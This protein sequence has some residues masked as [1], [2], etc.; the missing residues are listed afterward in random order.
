MGKFPH[1]QYAKINSDLLLFKVIN[2]INFF[3]SLINDSLESS[4]GKW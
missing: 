2:E 1:L 3:H 4:I